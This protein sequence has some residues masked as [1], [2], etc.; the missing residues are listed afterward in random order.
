MLCNTHLI[1]VLLVVPVQ[2]WLEIE[3]ATSTSLAPGQRRVLTYLGGDTRS[4]LGFRWLD[5]LPVNYTG[6][7]K[8]TEDGAM[9]QR[10]VGV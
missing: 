8:P 3:P 7:H 1:H 9:A 10:C 2:T 4:G 6:K 5:G